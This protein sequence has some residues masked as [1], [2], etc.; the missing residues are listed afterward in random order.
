M[1]CIRYEVGALAPVDLRAVLAYAGARGEAADLI[2]LLSECQEALLPNLTP[3]VVYE[4]FPVTVSGEDVSFGR[5]S[6]LSAGLARHL[7]AATSAAVFVA[8]L[9]IA[10]DRLIARYTPVSLATFAIASVS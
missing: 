7:A 1:P 8:T 9:G 5:F 3:R 10:P 2:P 6:V 4:I